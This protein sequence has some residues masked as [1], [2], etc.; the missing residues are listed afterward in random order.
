MKNSLFILLFILTFSISVFSQT[1]EQNKCPIISIA[2]PA[3]LPIGRQEVDFIVSVENSGEN[4]LEYIWTSSIG[5]IIKGQGTP[6]ITV[7]QLPEIGNVTVT[8]EIKGLPEGCPNTGSEA[9]G[10]HPVEAEAIQIDEFSIS[11][12]RIDKARLDYLISEMQ[13]DPSAQIYIIEYFPPQTTDAAIKRKFK[14][15]RDYIS[16]IRKQDISRFTFV[17]GNLD[18]N[19]TRFWLVPAG[20][21]PPM[22]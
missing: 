6:N 14:L 4:T 10:G 19:K 3:G 18:E 5:E 8:V 12:N 1:N 13:R 16:K 22:P 2:G 9:L 17:K 11:P 21:T 15:L 20:A 7:K